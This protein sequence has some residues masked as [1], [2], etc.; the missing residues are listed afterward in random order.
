MLSFGSLPW[1]RS[2]WSSGNGRLT[3]PSARC[4]MEV[5]ICNHRFC[6]GTNLSCKLVLDEGLQEW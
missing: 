5:N 6:I 2:N 3:I 4:D 1:F